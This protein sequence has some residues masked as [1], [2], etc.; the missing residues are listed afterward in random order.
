MMF[1]KNSPIMPLVNLSE[2]FGHSKEIFLHEFGKMRIFAVIW[3]RNLGVRLTA[4]IVSN[5]KKN[6]IKCIF[7]KC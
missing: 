4:N 5:K 2:I 1:C 3:V 6:W 7:P